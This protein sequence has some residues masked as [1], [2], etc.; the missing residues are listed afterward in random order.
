VA[1]LGLGDQDRITLLSVRWPSGVRQE[2]ENLA[3]DRLYIITE[4]TA[5][6]PAAPPAPIPPLFE[7]SE[8][9]AAARH[10]ERPFDD[11]ALQPLLPNKLSQFGPSMAW[12]DLD[13]D[14]DQDLFL[15]G[16]AGQAGQV[17]LS[18]EPGIFA[19]LGGETG[20]SSDR[21]CEDMGCAF[22]DADG[23][24]DLDLFVASGGVESPLGGVAY[25]DRL[26]L[27]QGPDASPRFVN[28]EEAL[29]DLRDSSGPVAVVD[30]DRDGDLDLFVGG[31]LVPGGYPSSPLS[32]LLTNE[33]GVFSVAGEPLALGMVTDALW[34]DIN[35][36][37]WPDLMVTTE[38][39]PVRS[40][41][42]R[43]GELIEHTA[44]SG[45]SQLLGWWNGIAGADVDG[46]GDLDFAVSNFGQNSKYHP[47]VEMPQVIYLGDLSASGTKNLVEAKLGEGGGLLPVRGKSCSVH[48]MPHL[49]KK[50]PTFH[51]FASASLEDIYSAA[52]LASCLRLEVNTLESGILL[53]DG[54]GT[55]RFRPFPRL[56]QV[57]P[58][59][60]V[61]F[62]NAD[63][64]SHP[65]LFM[66]QNF[67]APQRETGRMDGGL[68]ILLR[69]VGTG[70]FIP[71]S[72]SQSGIVIPGDATA[73]K[74][75]DLNGD[76]HPD[77]V[78]A[79]N[80][81]PVQVFLR[82]SK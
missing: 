15:G 38:Y 55:F 65:D 58:G 14:G 52:L 25:R 47:T 2:F 34:A 77:L 60:G 79:T 64:D 49:Q 63:G 57:S 69:G 73:V 8:M 13:G 33:G 68:S 40:F 3:A 43:D 28:A 26:Y 27:N 35:G 56:A 75:I 24:G 5:G 46:D 6:A 45:L 31:R 59:F 10:V 74:T 50:F 16:A 36:D 21:E 1:S 53:N 11:F 12:G 20:F 81:G 4:P 44:D 71:L 17:F 19:P 70:E 76:S 62:L 9:L 80:A 18:S 23:D 37:R 82:I 51:K 39:G 54:A 48:A 66:A 41:L 7:K 42:N 61:A 78:V 32:R 30:Y 67:F 29:P 72:P 22:F